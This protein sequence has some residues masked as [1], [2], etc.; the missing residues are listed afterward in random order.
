MTVAELIEALQRYPQDARVVL[1]NRQG[2]TMAWATKLTYGAVYE[3]EDFVE[4]PEP[5]G[6]PTIT[7]AMILGPG[8]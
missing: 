8:S 3:N 4:G 1:F 7:V 2:D 5:N 6:G